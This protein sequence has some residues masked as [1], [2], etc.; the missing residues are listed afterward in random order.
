DAVIVPVTTFGFGNAVLREEGAERQEAHPESEDEPF[1]AEPIWLLRE[2]VSAQPYNLDTLFLWTLLFGLL[3]QAGHPVL[4]EDTDL[5]Q[6]CRTLYEDLGARDPWLLPIK[7]GIA[8][9]GKQ[10]PEMQTAG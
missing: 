7:G 9:E 1:G 6:L 3:N 4:E 8:G 5:G 10:E 2:G